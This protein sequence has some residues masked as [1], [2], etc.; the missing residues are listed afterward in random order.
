[1]TSVMPTAASPMKV[2]TA[3]SWGLKGK[4]TAEKLL[5][6]SD[7]FHGVGQRKKSLQEKETDLEEEGERGDEDVS[8]MK[9]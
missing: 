3:C 7:L 9:S 4:K 2:R 6:E 1:M 5:F 8:N